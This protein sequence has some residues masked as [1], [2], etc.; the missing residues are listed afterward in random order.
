MD[1]AVTDAWGTGEI[2][3]ITTSQLYD[4]PEHIGFPLKSSNSAITG[5]LEDD[6]QLPRKSIEVTRKAAVT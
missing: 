3:R 5:E 4:N 2:L 1:A 6:W